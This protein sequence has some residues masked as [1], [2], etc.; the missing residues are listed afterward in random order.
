[1]LTAIITG[2]AATEIGGRISASVFKCMRRT[3]H[4]SFKDIKV[5][6]DTRL[7]IIN[8]ILFAAYHSVLVKISD[9][10]KEFT[11]CQKYIYGK[12]SFCFLGAFCQL[13]AIGGDCVYKNQN[14]IYWEQALNCMV[15]L[16]GTHRF[17]DCNDMKTIMTNMRDGILSTDEWNTL[18]SRV[19][20]G[21]EV[22]KPNPLKTKYATYYN[23][24]RSDIN[25]SVFQNYLKTYHNVNSGAGIPY[26]AI[27][28]K[29]VANWAKSK[30]PLS[31]D[32]RKVLF[33]E[34]P[35]SM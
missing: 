19:I 10:L 17:N 5:L 15:D 6:Q 33:R 16:K 29:T 12:H 11:E 28:I 20:N 30:T 27:V 32:Q 7:S 4:V 24:K 2:A 8:E 25:A 14:G 3:D 22:K 31:F 13:E 9:N 1:L 26:T 34:C 21:N 23:K 18:N 35:E